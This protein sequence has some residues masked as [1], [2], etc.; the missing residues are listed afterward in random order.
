MLIAKL[1]G[2]CDRCGS[3]QQLEPDHVNGR[4]WS[5]RSVSKEQRLQRYAHEFR[6]GVPLRDLCRH[7]NASD[8]A[9][10]GNLRRT[11]DSVVEEIEALE[12]ATELHNAYTMPGAFPC[13]PVHR[14]PAKL[15]L[16]LLGN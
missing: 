1:G 5:P 9:T 10:A 16:S 8:G 2:R 12:H 4:T 3:R 13:A 15:L 7:C 11:R 14:N 6:S